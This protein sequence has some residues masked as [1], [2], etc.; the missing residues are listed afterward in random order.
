MQSFPWGA[1]GRFGERFAGRFGER[2]GERVV[3]HRAGWWRGPL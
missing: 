2:P 1:S 3:G